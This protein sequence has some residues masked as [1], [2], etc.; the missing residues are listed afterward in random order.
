MSNV[1]LAKNTIFA[2]DKVDEVNDEDKNAE[3]K[4][5]YE[6]NC[7]D[8]SLPELAFAIAQF[9]KQLDEDEKIAVNKDGGKYFL[10]LLSTYYNSTTDDK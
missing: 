1:I 7:N 9:L 2:I 3:F 5:V 4:T 10:H 8:I 6:Y